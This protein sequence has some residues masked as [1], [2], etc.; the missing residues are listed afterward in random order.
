MVTT[1]ELREATRKLHSLRLQSVLTDF[2]FIE[3]GLRL[4]IAGAY[5]LIRKR[6]VGA[7]PFRLDETSLEKD[8]L[9]GLIL[10]FS[11]LSDNAELV[12]SMRALVPKRNSCAHRGFVAVTDP[13]MPIDEIQTAIDQLKETNVETSACLKELLADLHKLYEIRE[14]PV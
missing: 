1:T 12:K 7:I 13:D 14:R 5:E 3:E 6:L 10:K 9:G 11:Q 8:A 4:Y 2:Q